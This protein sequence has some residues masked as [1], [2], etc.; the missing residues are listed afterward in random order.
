MTLGHNLGLAHHTPAKSA[1]TLTMT[2]T[3][4]SGQGLRDG[5]LRTSLQINRLILSH[6]LFDMS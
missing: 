1:L 4:L 5:L 3:L 2:R 6:L